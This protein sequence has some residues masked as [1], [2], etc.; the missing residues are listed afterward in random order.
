MNRAG[1][2]LVGMSGILHIDWRVWWSSL[3]NVPF[4]GLWPIRLFCGVPSRFS[5]C[6][7]SAFHRHLSPSSSSSRA[8]PGCP[9]NPSS[10][11]V[12][13]RLLESATSAQTPRTCFLALVLAPA[14][15][16]P[17]AIR[18]ST[19]FPHRAAAATGNRPRNRGDGRG[20]NPAWS[21]SENQACGF[22]C[23]MPFL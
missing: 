9:R 12:R 18:S 1:P 5:P 15:W 4:S 8:S 14:A 7:R 2:L 16:G 10:R 19:T 13:C 23:P 11:A 21:S 3:E 20:L 6:V 17:C 22:G